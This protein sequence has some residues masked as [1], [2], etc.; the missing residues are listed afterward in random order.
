MTPADLQMVRRVLRAEG[1]PKAEH[2]AH[3]EADFGSIKISKMREMMPAADIRRAM[4]SYRICDR[5]RRARSQ[6]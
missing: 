5:L 3:I 1:I 2:D 4:Q 6:P